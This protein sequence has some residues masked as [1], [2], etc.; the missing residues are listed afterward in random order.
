MYIHS[1]A[2][3]KLKF[4]A[5]LGERDGSNC[6]GHLGTGFSEILQENSLNAIRVWST[7]T[8]V[9]SRIL[10]KTFLLILKGVRK[11]T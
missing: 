4:K 5:L 1:N 9:I 7:E 8:V 6:M 10:K 3:Y 2:S 11:G